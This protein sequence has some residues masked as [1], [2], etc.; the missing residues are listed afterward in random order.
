MDPNPD[1]GYIKFKCSWHHG[2][3]QPADAIRSL[4]RWRQILYEKGLL[5]AYPDGVGFGNVSQRAFRDHFYITGSKTGNLTSLSEYHYARVTDFD[6]SNNRVHCMGPI[7]ASS[8]SM[9]HAVIYRQLPEVQAVFHVHSAPLWK[10]LL[11]QIPTTGPDIPYG[12]PEM[13]MEIV[14]LI[15]ETNVSESGLFAMAGHQ[16]GLFA[17]GKSLDAAGETLLALMP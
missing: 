11:N 13:A 5:G 8:E 9:S 7:I 3:P 2:P 17:F 14:R 1:E 16:D 6:I 10:K 4:N 12:T 15:R